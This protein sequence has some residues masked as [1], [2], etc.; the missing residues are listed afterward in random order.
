MKM[1]RKRGREP[2]HRD[3]MLGQRHAAAK[4]WHGQCTGMDLSSGSV[5]R[6]WVEITGFAPDNGN[7][8]VRTRG[9]NVCRLQY[10]RVYRPRHF[11]SSSSVIEAPG[12][13]S[14]ETQIVWRLGV[15]CAVK[16]IDHRNPIRCRA[17]S[18]LRQLT[19]LCASPGHE[20]INYQDG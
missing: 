5:L 9:R 16:E 2:S 7:G 17:A 18:R 10:C 4:E 14:C 19:P 13:D 8:K 1:S 20:S 3:L 15:P 12:L 11:L 6:R